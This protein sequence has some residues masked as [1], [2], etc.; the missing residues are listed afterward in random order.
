[1]QIGLYIRRARSGTLVKSDAAA[2]CCCFAADACAQGVDWNSLSLFMMRSF[3]PV[4]TAEGTF[5]HRH[6]GV[7]GGGCH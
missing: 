1:M 5:L 6:T 7:Q 2:L 3:M 4:L